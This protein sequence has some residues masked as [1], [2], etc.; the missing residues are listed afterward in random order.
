MRKQIPCLQKVSSWAPG[1]TSPATTALAE[2]GETEA[3]TPS[4]GGAWSPATFEILCKR[5]KSVLFGTQLKALSYLLDLWSLWGKA[6][7]T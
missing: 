2:K 7:C 5:P 1:S 3:S 6:L 4:K